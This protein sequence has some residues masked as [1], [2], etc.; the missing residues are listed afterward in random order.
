M[1]IM[2]KALMFLAI[3]ALMAS[4]AL[5]DYDYCVNSSMSGHS[6]FKTTANGTVLADV[7]WNETC[8]F[9]CSD[10]TG[11]C[12]PDPYA[13]ENL[14]FYLIFPV[15]AFILLYFTSILK[16]ED[17]IMHIILIGAALLFLSVPLGT[18]SNSMPSQFTGLYY[19]MVTLDFV[20]V[21]YYIIKLMV[22]AF[23][24]AGMKT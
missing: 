4:P 15:I 7:V 3:L 13:Q 22:R 5:A 20:V 6:L 19:L 12:N 9:N 21:F 2:R 24:A 14:T 18:L 10:N 16:E 23:G 1:I 11:K 17:W 8:H